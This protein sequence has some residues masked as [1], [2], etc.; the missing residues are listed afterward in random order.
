MSFHACGP[1]VGDMVSIPLPTFVREAAAADPDILYADQH[2]YH[3]PECL[4]LWADNVV[5]KGG[6]TPLQCYADFMTSFRVSSA[7]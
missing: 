1:D 2:G 4:S 6:R 7:E 5:L 3:N